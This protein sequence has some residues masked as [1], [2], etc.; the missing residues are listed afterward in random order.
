[1]A[2][3]GQCRSQRYSIVGVYR[4]STSTCMMNAPETRNIL[5]ECLA[6]SLLACWVLVTIMV[7][8]SSFRVNSYIYH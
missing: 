4:M 5:P 6:V 8:P 2:F 3:V 7:F 1:M